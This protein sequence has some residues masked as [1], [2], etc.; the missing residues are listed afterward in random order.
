M[1]RIGHLWPQV[2][3]FY[4]LARA[5]ERARKRKR[6]RED[7]QRAVVGRSPDRPTS[8]TVGLQYFDWT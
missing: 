4:S 7:V 3:S 5:A 6:S 1:K 2:I 8:P